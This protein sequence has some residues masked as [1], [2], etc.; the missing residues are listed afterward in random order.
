[1][2]RQEDILGKDL[3][4]DQEMVAHQEPVEVHQDKDHCQDVD[5]IHVYVVFTVVSTLASV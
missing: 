4:M 3:E 2:H 1:M 5:S